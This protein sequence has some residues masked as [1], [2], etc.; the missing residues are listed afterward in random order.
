MEPSGP[1][2]T[3]ELKGV[4]SELPL[5]PYLNKL[6]IKMKSVRQQGKGEYCLETYYREIMK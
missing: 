2:M 4:M 1:Q 5:N 3:N 6:I